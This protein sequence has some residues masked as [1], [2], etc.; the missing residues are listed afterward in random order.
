MGAACGKHERDLAARQRA[1]R[2]GRGRPRRPQALI[3]VPTSHGSNPNNVSVGPLL[4][5]PQ[6]LRREEDN[7]GG[8]PAAAH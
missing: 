1:R 4:L 6:E 3:N 7:S 5:L 8:E 2:R